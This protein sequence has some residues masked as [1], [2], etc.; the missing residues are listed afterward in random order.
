MPRAK[1]STRK[2][3]TRADHDRYRAELSAGQLVIGMSILL[4]ICLASFLM[5]VV[6]GKFDPSL[7]PE[8]ALESRPIQEVAPA[9][10]AGDQ[11]PSPVRTATQTRKA[12]PPELRTPRTTENAQT[13][14]GKQA[15]KPKEPKDSAVTSAKAQPAEAKPKTEA[16]KPSRPDPEPEKV[17]RSDAADATSQPISEPEKS[18]ATPLLRTRYGAQV[19]AFTTRKRAEVVKRDVETR[20]A[21]KAEIVLSSSG[22]LF[23]VVVGSYAEYQSASTVRDDLKRHF[24]FS[25]C[26]VTTLQ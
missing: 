18:Q 1:T 23:K 12:P 7:N 6:V 3:K 24:G 15:S 16:D 5:G 17:A 21:Y 9:P 10:S 26:F 19:A 13:S 20:S 4:M 22:R 25:D 2:S 8:V 14:G 11:T